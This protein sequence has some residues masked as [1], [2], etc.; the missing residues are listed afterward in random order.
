MRDVDRIVRPLF[1]YAGQHDP[2]V[3]RRE[4]DTIV[5]ALRSR[6]VP[7]EYMVAASEGHSVD[8]RATKL[9]LF[10]RLARFLEDALR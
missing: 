8:R 7:V 5:Q 6:K 1:V 9:E 2:R 4:S 10:T 3:P